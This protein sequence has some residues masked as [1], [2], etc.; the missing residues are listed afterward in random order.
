MNFGSMLYFITQ[1]VQYGLHAE[2]ILFAD[3]MLLADSCINSR[4]HIRNLLFLL[5]LFSETAYEVLIF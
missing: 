5:F 3:E 1:L 2:G 4:E